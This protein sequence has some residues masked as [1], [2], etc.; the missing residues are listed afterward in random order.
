MTFWVE[1][2]NEEQGQGAKKKVQAFN[3]N[4]STSTQTLPASSVWRAFTSL[5]MPDR[6]ATQ[7]TLSHNLEVLWQFESVFVVSTG[8]H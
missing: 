8:A 4:L 5:R 2:G 7:Q 6:A 1:W 3:A